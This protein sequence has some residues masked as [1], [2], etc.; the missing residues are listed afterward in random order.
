MSKIV[1]IPK[2]LKDID[3]GTN[4]LDVGFICSDN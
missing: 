2:P 3:E 4:T 1:C